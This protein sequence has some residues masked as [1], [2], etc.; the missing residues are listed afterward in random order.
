MLIRLHGKAVLTAR[1]VLTLLRNGYSSG[2]FARW[3]TL[4]EVRVMSCLCWPTATKI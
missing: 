4:H 3:R 2:A 1:E